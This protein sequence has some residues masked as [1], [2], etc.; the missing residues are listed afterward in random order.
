MAEKLRILVTGLVAEYPL[1]GMT[2][3]YLQYLLGF[4]RLGHDVY[5]IEDTGGW[6]YNPAEQVLAYE[7]DHNVAYLAGIME[8]FG[9]GDRWA[10]RVLGDGRDWWIGLGDSKRKE[11]IESADMLINI[12]GT[13]HT[14][15]EYQSV[16][17]KVYIDTD[18]V[19]IQIRLKLDE[20]RWLEIVHAHDVHFSFGEL[21]NDSF[22]TDGL[23]WR[24][25]RQ[26]VVLSEWL[27][28]KHPGSAYTT[29]M[30]W[31]SYKSET[32]Q[33]QRFGQKDVEFMR[34]MSLPQILDPVAF[35]LAVSPGHSDATPR[36][37]LNQN[38]WRLVDPRAVCPDLD[39]YRSYILSS[40][41][42]WSVAK[43][44]YVQGWSGWFSERSACFLAAGR[45]VIVQDTGFSSI[46]PTGDGIM[47]FSTLD[48]AVQAVRD[49]EA[50][51]ARHARAARA[52]AEEWFDSDKVLARL[53]DDAYR[54]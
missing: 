23:E 22:P 26:P 50:N 36:K 11:V 5:Y 14:P 3:H 30:N 17:R 32:F 45:P 53:I 24:P 1:G 41:G 7:H 33:G 29:V 13:L 46:L 52:I 54:G 6:P 47:N 12:S 20:R 16:P 21:V 51:Y 38:G 48:Q 37:L 8:R 34:F 39:S 25:T 49:V 40:R 9:F 43:N 2:W 19:F 28:S 4:R 31:T 42:E 27:N 44:A 35:E 18:P 10:Y 15:E